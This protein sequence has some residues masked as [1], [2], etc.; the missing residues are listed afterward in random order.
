MPRKTGSLLPADGQCQQQNPEWEINSLFTVM[1][2]HLFLWREP[3]VFP[4]FALS[5]MKVDQPL[6]LHLTLFFKKDLEPTDA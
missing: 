1:C 2:E 3:L 5:T 6:G 4:C